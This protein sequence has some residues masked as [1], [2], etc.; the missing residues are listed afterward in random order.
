MEHGDLE[1]ELNNVAAAPIAIIY[2]GAES[3]FIPD[4]TG[5]YKTIDI[6]TFWLV[7]E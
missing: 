7:Y 5:F 1:R 6:P 4:D 3:Y 2:M